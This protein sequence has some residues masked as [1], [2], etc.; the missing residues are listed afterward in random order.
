MSVDWHALDHVQLR[1]EDLRSAFPYLA[2]SRYV[3]GEGPDETPKAFVVGEAP[4]AQEEARLKPFVGP[5]GLILRQLM[6]IGGLE[7]AECWITN[8]MKYRSVRNKRPTQEEMKAFRLVLLDEWHAVGKPPLIVTVGNVA[9]ATILGH[10]TSVVR[11]AGKP[12]HRNN[13]VVVFPMISAAYGRHEPKAREL[14]ESHWEKL[15]EWIA[16]ARVQ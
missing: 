12:M 7:P 13:G 4:G 1:A 11:Q 8:A 2:Q 3:P 15:N 16:T 5:D 6:R 10:P 9:L 14:I